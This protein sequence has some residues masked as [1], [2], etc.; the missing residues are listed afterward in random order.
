MVQSW[1]TS[2]SDIYYNSGNVGIRTA[3]PSYNLQIGNAVD[4]TSDT[5]LT[6]ATDGGVHIKVE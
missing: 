1:T 2:S 5:F 3:D 6:I 4:K